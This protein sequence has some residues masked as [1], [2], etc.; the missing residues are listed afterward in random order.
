[1]RRWSL[2]LYAQQKKYSLRKMG[3][4]Q[5]LIRQTCPAKYSRCHNYSKQGH[6]AKCCRA[7]SRV[8]MVSEVELAENSSSY[9]KV[10]L[11]EVSANEHKPWT[12]DI[13]VSKDCLTLKL[14]SDADVTVLQPS[15]YN[16]LT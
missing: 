7:K 9:S 3:H 10:Y 11:D 12:V 15:T 2:E 1:M 14:D 13:I 6:F 8:N 16:K 4:H 5:K